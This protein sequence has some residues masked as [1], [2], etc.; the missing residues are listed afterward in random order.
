MIEYQCG[1]LLFL[2]G[3]DRT[4]YG[5]WVNFWKKT[6]YSNL[7]E[8]YDNNISM[9]SVIKSYKKQFKC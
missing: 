5:L 2:S 8:L 4:Y 6:L 9:K 1:P 7:S 3:Y